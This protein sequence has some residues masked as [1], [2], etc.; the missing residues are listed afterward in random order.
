MGYDENYVQKVVNAAGLSNKEKLDKISDNF[1]SEGYLVVMRTENQLQMVKKKKF[2]FFWAFIWLLF[3]GFGLL[4]YLFY[5]MAKDDK[6]ISVTLD[7]EDVYSRSGG[8]TFSDEVL[9]LA[10]LLERGLITREEF[11]IQKGKL[12]AD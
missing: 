10:D 7:L 11:D 4:V 8:T 1:M 2:S 12:L 6:K 5:Y 9:K 3:W